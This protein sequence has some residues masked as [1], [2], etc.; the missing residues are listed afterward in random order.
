MKMV[1][2]IE[3]DNHGMIGIAKDYPSAI[4]FLV[5]SNWLD[6]KFEVW[7]DNEISL[8]Q[9]LEDH[10]GELWYVAIRDEWDTEQFNNFFNGSFYL[11]IEGVYGT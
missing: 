9:T 7:V 10:L 2:L 4:D 3:E 6:G 5:D 8:T 1:C 11:T